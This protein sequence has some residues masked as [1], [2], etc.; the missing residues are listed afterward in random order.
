MDSRARGPVLIVGAGA[1][2]LAI[3]WRLASAG[4][5]VVIFDRSQAGRGTSWLA[6]G[7][8]APD[9]EIGFEELD[10]HRLNRE[11]LRRWPGFAAD[12]EE[13]SGL[14]IDLQLHGTL[15]VADDRDAAEALRRRYAFMRAHGLDV[16]WLS[17]AEA[18]A[19]EPFLAP[20]LAAVVHSPSDGQ[21]DNRLLL[22][23]LKAAFLH[24]GGVLHERTAI[25]VVEPDEALPAVVTRSGERIH[26][27]CVLLTAGAWSRHVGGLNAVQNPPIRPVKGQM[28]EFGIEPPFDLRQVVRGPDVYVVPKSGGRLLVG[29]T[30]EEM[31]YDVRVTGGG[32]YTLLEGAWKIVPGIYDLPLTDA[33]AGLRPA[34]RDHRPI[35]GASSA[36]GVILATGFYRH[37]ILLTPVVAEE[38]ARL[39]LHGETSDWIEPF[40]PARF[41][42]G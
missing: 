32:L 3:G 15:L 5:D 16:R 38:I 22:E 26:G 36:P 1:A 8:L 42:A 35:L 33:W 23:A 21:V 20:R 4:R 25:R 9:A 34:S 28:I 7:M 2:G 29:A 37:G 10:L 12:L 14:G 11:S 19:I 30:S 41:R 17:G 39:V 27:T 13:E 18:L 31:G 6:A 24:R 40:L